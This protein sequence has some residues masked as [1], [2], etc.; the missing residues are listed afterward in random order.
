MTFHPWRK[1]RELAH[2]RLE[3]QN[4]DDEMGCADTSTDTVTITTGMTQAER[5]S[6][7]THELIHLER[8]SAVGDRHRLIEERH[9]Q[10]ESARRLITLD[11][12]IDALRW[13]HDEHEL[14][15]ELWT[16]VDTVRTRLANLSAAERRFIDAELDRREAECDEGVFDDRGAVG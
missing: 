16:D 4:V 15:D 7:L 14:A 2:I 3:W 10:R 6:T 11:A 13:S 12:L 1:L 5:R 9:V 8:G